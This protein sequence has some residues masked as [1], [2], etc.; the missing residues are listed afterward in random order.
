MI[1]KMILPL[2][3]LIANR[4][5]RYELCAATMRRADQLSI[6]AD[7]EVDANGGKVVPT[8]VKQVL[9]KKVRYE[10]ER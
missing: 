7:E 1:L 4:T 5:N 3:L 2:G 9:T 8:A 6:A 10:I